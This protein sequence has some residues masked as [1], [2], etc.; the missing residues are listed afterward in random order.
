LVHESLVTSSIFESFLGVRDLV[1]ENESEP[2]PIPT[3]DNRATCLLEHIIVI[4][5]TVLVA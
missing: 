5:E 2:Q 3:R 1:V 4:L